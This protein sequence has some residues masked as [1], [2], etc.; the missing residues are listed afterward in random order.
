MHRALVLSS[1]AMQLAVQPQVHEQRS[2]GA[3]QSVDLEI[4]AMS[5]IENS[6]SQVL[7]DMLVTSGAACARTKG[8]WQ[9][10]SP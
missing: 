7:M 6:A 5:W 9:R 8:C 10:H 4:V 2:C 1:H 3:H